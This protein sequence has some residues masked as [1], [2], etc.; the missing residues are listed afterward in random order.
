M[1]CGNSI[2]TTP[3]GLEKDSEPADEI[4]RVRHLGEDV[5][6]AD[7]VRPLPFGGKLT[8][9]LLSE[10]FHAGGDPLLDSHLGHVGRGLYPEHRDP[11]PHEVLK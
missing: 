11:F 3:P 6:A 9:R 5:R 7:Q 10:E 1:R 4:V 2:V 8:R